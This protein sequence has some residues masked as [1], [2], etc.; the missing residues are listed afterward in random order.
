MT[1]IKDIKGMYEL[2]VD[3]TRNIVYEEFKGKVLRGEDLM[4]M[5][6]DYVNKVKPKLRPGAWAKLSDLRNYKTS[7][8]VNEA[9]EHLK[10]C[11]EN[12]MKLGAVVVENMIAKMQMERIGKNSGIAPTI[13]IDKKEADNWLKTQGF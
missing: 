3:S 13:F 9:N 5:H 11:L 12:G 6:Q 8:I 2:K 4:R 1:V 7:M 10:W